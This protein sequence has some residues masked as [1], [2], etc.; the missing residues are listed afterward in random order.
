MSSPT[1]TTTTDTTTT[2]NRPPWFV[3][4]VANP[5]LGFLVERV[6]FSFGGTE[7]LAVRGR[8]SGQIR[9][10]PVN[11]LAFD[12]SWYLFS[13]RGDTDWVRNLR[14]AGQGEL[15][16]GGNVR[17]FRV[18]EELSDA[19]KPPVIRAYMERWGKQVGFVGFDAR[20]SDAVLAEA[21]PKHPV[22]RIAFDPVA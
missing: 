7:M 13:P 12:G 8:K 19:E 5:V 11:P 2:Y 21:A 15:A 20:A 1:T 4:R 17:A 3:A 22:F 18:V 10:V 14:A 16:R 9:K 6:G